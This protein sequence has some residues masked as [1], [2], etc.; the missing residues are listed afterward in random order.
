MLLE[1]GKREKGKGK[2]EKGGAPRAV[3]E[4]DRKSKK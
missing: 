3:R 1:K 2:R 4:A